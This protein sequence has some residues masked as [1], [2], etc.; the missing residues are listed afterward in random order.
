MSV[1]RIVVFT[2][3]DWLGLDNRARINTPGMATGNWEWRI[4]DGALTAR[5]AEKMKNMTARYD[6]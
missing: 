3:A 2:M 4:G 5:L 1:S 6:R